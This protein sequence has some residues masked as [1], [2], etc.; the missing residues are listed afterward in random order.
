[1]SRL[2]AAAPVAIY[3]TRTD[4]KWLVL[5]RF[6]PDPQKMIEKINKK[7][8]KQEKM[9]PRFYQDRYFSWGLKER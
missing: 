6:S 5:W 1:M 8:K 4:C 2:K 7:M 3:M 9:A